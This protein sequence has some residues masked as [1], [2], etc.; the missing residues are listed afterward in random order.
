M[1]PPGSRTL[2]LAFL[3]MGLTSFGGGM[4][5][6]MMREFVHR[7][8]WLSEDD[9]LNG[10]SVAQAMPGINITNLAIWTG[11]RL[12]G[13]RLAALA[14]LAIVAP[15]ALIVVAIATVFSTITG[16]DWAQ[17]G[18]AGAASAAVAM[19]AQMGI[20]ATIRLRRAW[21]PYLML[22]ATFIAVGVVRL[23][24]VWV[25]LVGGAISVAVEYRRIRGAGRR[26]V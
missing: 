14:F 13:I 24:L 9:F 23:P 11:Y 4:S 16:S 12:G 20:V 3:R 25:V 15:P 10:L 22:I 19:S 1:A 6:W 26:D 7:R 8:H 18:M 2:F 5:G 17:A 21:F